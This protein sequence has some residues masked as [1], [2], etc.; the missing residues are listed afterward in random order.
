MFKYNF[1][2]NVR[3]IVER[4]TAQNTLLTVFLEMSR[5]LLFSLQLRAYC[6]TTMY[7]ATYPTLVEDVSRTLY[8]ERT[9]YFE[10]RQPFSSL[11]SHRSSIMLRG[12]TSS[13]LGCVRCMCFTC[14]RASRDTST[15]HTIERSLRLEKYTIFRK[16]VN[17][18]PLENSSR[19]AAHR[20][21]GAL[22]SFNCVSSHLETVFVLRM[23]LLVNFL[24]TCNEVIREMGYSPSL[25]PA[26]RSCEYANVYVRRIVQIKTDIN[27]KW[28]W[29]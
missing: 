17:L 11:L 23:Q 12:I 20:K 19:W 3:L 25:A 8:V 5:N 7:C 10:R 27:T 28:H 29:T 6:A 14:T 15:T 2:G 26:I 9:L 16:V 24:E 18:R 21:N 22:P 13:E 1:L 4:E